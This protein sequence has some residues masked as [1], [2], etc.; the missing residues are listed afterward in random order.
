MYPPGHD[1]LIKQHMT[2]IFTKARPTALPPHGRAST[3]L[4]VKASIWMSQQELQKT[5]KTCQVEPT[6]NAVNA[7]P[8]DIPVK[9]SSWGTTPCISP[10]MQCPPK[11]RG[12]KPK[13]DKVDDENN[14]NNKDSKGTTAKA[15][16]QSSK[17]NK[18]TKSK[19]AAEASSSSAKTPSARMHEYLKEQ[20]GKRLKAE[21][22]NHKEEDNNEGEEEEKK[23]KQRMAPMMPTT[24]KNPAK[25]T[26][27][28]REPKRA[29]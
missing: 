8:K 2:D 3:T 17:A 7:E 29:R 18:S 20:K 22:E 14:N 12:R 26:S 28:R 1:V 6:N 21:E 27:A 11:K 13:G 19:T 23:W 5:K 15:K 9:P 16:M 25:V 24:A 10:D 4:D